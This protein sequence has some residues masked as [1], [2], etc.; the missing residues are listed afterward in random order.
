MSKKP[1][2]VI[3]DKNDNVIGC[4]YREDLTPKKDIYRVSALWVTNSKGEVLCAQRSFDKE[5][6]PG[7]WGPAVSGTVEEGE[8]REENIYKE[9]EE[10]LGI[11][12]IKFETGPKYST[13]ERPNTK[14]FRFTQWFL[15]KIDR[16]TEDFKLQKEEV[17]QVRWLTEEEILKIYKKDSEFFSLGIT[18]WIKLFMNK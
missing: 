18:T 14:H 7:K 15:A 10:E 4:K 1:K 17:E 6:N 3:V 13:L 9:A 12:D 11:K 16:K 2:I 8:T 5:H